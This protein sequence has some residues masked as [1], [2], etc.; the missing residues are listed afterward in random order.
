MHALLSEQYQCDVGNYHWTPHL[1]WHPPFSRYPSVTSNDMDKIKGANVF[2]SFVFLY[3]GRQKIRGPCSFALLQISLHLYCTFWAVQMLRDLNLSQIQG[4]N[5]QFLWG[6]LFGR[7][8]KSKQ[9]YK[10]HKLLLSITLEDINSVA[11]LFHI[12]SSTT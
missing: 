6:F 5:S 2:I 4:W 11:F 10:Y 9:V 7:Y 3:G 8:R 12:R 1:Q